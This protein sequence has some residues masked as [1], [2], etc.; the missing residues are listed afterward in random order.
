MV[1]VLF[2]LLI[3]FLDNF[4]LYCHFLSCIAVVWSS[5]RISNVRIIETSLAC[6]LL[7][8][9]TLLSHY[10]HDFQVTSLPAI[11]QSQYLTAVKM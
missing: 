5:I 2:T 10:F 11:Y 9:S 6:M 4:R 7:W 3:D 8:Q 1:L